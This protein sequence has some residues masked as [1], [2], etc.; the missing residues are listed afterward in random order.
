MNDPNF[1]LER[2]AGRLGQQA[3]DALDVER[4]AQGVL[5]R[6]R[7]QER[8]WWRSPALLQ[9]AAAV[10]VV[11]GGTL[12][13]ARQRA[14]SPATPITAAAAGAFEGLSTAELREVLDSLVLDAPPSSYVGRGL[15]DLTEAQLKELL[16]T[17]E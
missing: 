13:V 8:P 1:D 14:V 12:V 7:V 4:A 15:H 3:A 10:A 5:R 16:E 9:M 6:L 2:A 11:A 17:E